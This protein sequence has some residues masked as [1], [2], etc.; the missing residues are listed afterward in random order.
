[1]FY[2]SFTLARSSNKALQPRNATQPEIQEVLFVFRCSVALRCAA[3]RCIALRCAVLRC[4]A[5][6]CA[7]LLTNYQARS[8][9]AIRNH[10]AY[11]ASL[12]IVL[13]L[14]ARRPSSQQVC[15]NYCIKGSSGRLKLTEPGP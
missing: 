3:L 12:S 1:M 11:E 8:C 6:R 9:E 13:S 2:L 4:V 15:H 10:S 7:A 5:L 14:L